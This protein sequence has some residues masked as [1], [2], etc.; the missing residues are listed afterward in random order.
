[1]LFFDAR[2]KRQTETAFRRQQFSSGSRLVRTGSRG[3]LH[4]RMLHYCIGTVMHLGGGV[5]PKG[6]RDREPTTS[7]MDTSSLSLLQLS[8][9]VISTLFWR[10]VIS[11]VSSVS[12]HQRDSQFRVRVKAPPGSGFKLSEWLVTSPR[13][14]ST[15]NQSCEP[16]HSA[17]CRLW[18]GQN[19]ESRI[20]GL[21]TFH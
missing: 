16:S 12:C 6:A 7:L 9:L 19:H 14:T 13:P 21:S 5:M 1:M 3:G 17:A 18:P 4:D 10:D 11:D 8:V 20:R 2:K 15:R